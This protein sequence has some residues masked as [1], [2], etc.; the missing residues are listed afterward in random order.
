MSRGPFEVFARNFQYTEEIQHETQPKKMRVWGRL[1]QNFCLHGIQSKN[2]DQP[3]QNQG[4]RRYHSTRQYKGHAKVN[5]AHNH[6]RA[7]HLEVLR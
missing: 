2:Q 5:R 6:P 7:I 1:C 4:Y 3:R